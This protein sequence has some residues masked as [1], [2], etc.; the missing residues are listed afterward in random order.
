[1]SGQ[2][3]VSITE[4]A[5]MVGITRQTFHRHI[6]S[7]KITIV[8]RDIG[9]PKVEVSELTRIYGNRVKPLQELAEDIKQKKLLTE[10]PS[11][12]TLESIME[13]QAL[14]S[15]VQHLEELRQTEK[16]AAAEKFE[17]QNQQISLL[18]KLL[19]AE[20][21]EKRRTTALLT[22]Q[23]SEKEKQAEKLAALE[24]ELSTIK[25]AGFFAR[26]FGFGQKSPG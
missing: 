2:A 12:E 4:A 15:K 22:D 26:L 18:N 6:K 7:K 16:T 1:M 10:S 23:R 5:S 24:K 19:A 8:D 21:Q 25:S 13:L 20:E 11:V 9:Q 17:Q 3:F 14:R